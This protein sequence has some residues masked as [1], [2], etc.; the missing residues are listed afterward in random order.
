MPIDTEMKKLFTGLFASTAGILVSHPALTI[1]VNKQ[2]IGGKPLH[3]YSGVGL[4]MAKSVPANTITF[5][6]LENEKIKKLPAWTQGA[7]TRIIA[8]TIVYPLSLWSTRRQVGD[9]SKAGYFKGLTPTLGRD[10]LFSAVFL[11]IHRGWLN[12]P[13]KNWNVPLVVSLMAAATGA[14]I[15]TQPMD[16]V[17]VKSQLGMNMRGIGS[18]TLWRIAYCNCRSVVAWGIYSFLGKS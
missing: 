16:W 2:V 14:S 17:K 11:Q 7:L 8:E 5:Y 4:Y 12:N 15:A 3:L 1:K 6:L 18:G 13:E 10:L 9:T